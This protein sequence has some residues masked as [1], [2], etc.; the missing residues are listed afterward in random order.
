M[1]GDNQGRQSDSP[2]F[3]TTT[4]AAGAVSMRPMNRRDWLKT[5]MGGASVVMGLT[6]LVLTTTASQVQ[7]EIVSEGT[8][9]IN[10]AF[11]GG[12]AKVTANADSSVH[13]EPD[14]RGGRP[15]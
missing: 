9:T 6:V 4:Q 13:L 14:L 15:W 3:V 11:P 7:A 2:Y 10:T 1:A 5:T 8:V 12:N